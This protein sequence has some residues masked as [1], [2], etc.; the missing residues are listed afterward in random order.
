VLV[1]GGGVVA[2]SAVRS[3]ARARPAGP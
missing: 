1:F 3:M 2:A